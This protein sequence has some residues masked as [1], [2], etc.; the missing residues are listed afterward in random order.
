MAI[1]ETYSPGLSGTDELQAIRSLEMYEGKIDR[2]IEHATKI[3]VVSNW[4]AEEAISFGGEAKQLAKSIDN[5]RKAITDPA[6]KFVNKMNDVAKVFT[7]KLEQ[8]ESI[9]KAKVAAWKR[10]QAEKIAKE[11]ESAKALS[12][13]LGIEVAAYIVD[14]PKNIRG[15]GAMSYEQTV[16]RYEIEDES[17]IPREYLSVDETKI[18]G[19]VKAGI[20]SIPGLKIFSEQKMIIK[21]R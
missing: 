20:R 12:E 21:S 9:I 15:D 6:R 17:L 2:I 14:A 8:V 13:S 19:V 3:T 1:V 10:A 4:S 11:E 7:E 5:A 16:W 18:K